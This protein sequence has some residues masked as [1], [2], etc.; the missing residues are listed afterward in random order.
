MPESCDWSGTGKAPVMTRPSQAG[1][2]GADLLQV[3][4]PAA[5]VP[6]TPTDQAQAG[7]LGTW[8]ARLPAEV[9]SQVAGIPCTCVRCKH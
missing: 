8:L 3:G 2:A 9:A 6:L 5:D 1:A 7:A 4:L